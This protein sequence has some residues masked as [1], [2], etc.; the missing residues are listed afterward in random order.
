[1]TVGNLRFLIHKMA[2]LNFAFEPLNLPRK[3]VMKNDGR[4]EN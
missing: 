1:M 4:E 2:T 3:V